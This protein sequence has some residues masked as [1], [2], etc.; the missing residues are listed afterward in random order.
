[1]Y[2]CCGMQMNVMN[3]NDY[4]HTCECIRVLIN[5]FI[6][7]PPSR[8]FPCSVCDLYPLYVRTLF[9]AT[10]SQKS[11]GSLVFLPQQPFISLPGKVRG[12]S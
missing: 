7:G 4:L 1:M 12:S 6:S 8:N 10:P 5:I 3:I 9:G 2:V 11:N